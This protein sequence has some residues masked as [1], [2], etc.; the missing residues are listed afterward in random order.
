M[1]VFGELRDRERCL[2]GFYDGRLLLPGQV[3]IE[4]KSERFLKSVLGNDYQVQELIVARMRISGN[5][6]HRTQSW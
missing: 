1:K 2:S 6:G 4:A 3:S 5:V